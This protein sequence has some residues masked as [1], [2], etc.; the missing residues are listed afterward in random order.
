MTDDRPA[1]GPLSPLAS[2]DLRP[3]RRPGGRRRRRSATPSGPTGS[4]T[5]CCSSARAGPARRRSRGSSPRRSTARTC[6]TASRATP[7]RPCVSIREGTTLDLVEIDAAE[8]PRHRRHPR[9]ARAPAVPAR[10]APPQGLHPRRG[11]PD[12]EGRLERAPQVARG[13]ARLRRLHLR[14]DRAVGLPA[15]DPVA[16]PALRRP[17]PDGPRDRGQA[18]HGSSPPTGARPTPPRSHLIARLAAGGM[19]D[20]E[21][22]L[23]QLLVG[24]ARARSTSRRC[25]TCSAWPTRRRRRV[26]RPRWSA[27][28]RAAGIAL[29]DDARRARSRHP[30]ASSTRSSRPSATEL[31]RRAR[32]PGGR[33]PT[34]RRRSRP[35][36]ARL[37]AIDPNRAG[38]RRPPLPARARAV[39]AAATVATDRLAARRSA[40]RRRPPRRAAA[41]RPRRRPPAPAAGHDGP[42]RRASRPD[43]PSA[44]APARLPVDDAGSAARQP[45]PRQPPPPADATTPPRQPAPP[46][47]GADPAG[48]RRPIPAAPTADRRPPRRPTTPSRSRPCA[49]W[50]EI[51]DQLSA[52]PADQAAHPACRPVAVDGAIVTLGFPEEQAFLKDAPSAAARTS[53]PASPRPRAIRSPSAASST[54]VELPRRRRRRRHDLVAEARRIFADDLV[55]VGE[56]S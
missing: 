42:R 39:H 8:Q 15:G 6:A 43:A 23:D 51:V 36:A 18:R 26:R 17:A 31:V 24:G 35:P 47:A 48:R 56:V 22:M 28:T 2:P 16:P 37:A 55:D 27:A 40:P 45:P 32:R 44:S 21:S 4:P 10:A 13:A 30:G 38:H 1:P 19:R 25:A 7:V 34:T 46:R 9:A 49:A 52:A 11:A 29:L 5:P 50:P 14:L 33:A 20:A 12:H 54:N 3:D 41:A 53:R